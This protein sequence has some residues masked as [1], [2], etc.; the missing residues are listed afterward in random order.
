MLTGQPVREWHT[1]ALC[2]AQSSS[3]IKKGVVST[4]INLM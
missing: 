3:Q 4:G 2:S 1:C